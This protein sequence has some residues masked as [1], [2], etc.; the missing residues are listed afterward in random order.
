MV[1]LH[2]NVLTSSNASRFK[3]IQYLD[4]RLLF[5]SINVIK[6]YGSIV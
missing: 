2:L 6:T 4:N 5:V 1:Y 3:M